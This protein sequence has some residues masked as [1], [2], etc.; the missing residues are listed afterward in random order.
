MMRKTRVILLI[1]LIASS[2][3]LV[4]K[5]LAYS[6]TKSQANSS[7]YK[8]SKTQSHLIVIYPRG[9]G[10]LDELLEGMMYVTKSP[11][12]T[13]LNDNLRELI[14][15]PRPRPIEVQDVN[16]VRQVSEELLRQA[17][18]RF[19]L[20]R[21]G[22]QN[23]DSLFS[24]LQ[25][26]SSAYKLFTQEKRN[27]RIWNKAELKVKDDELKKVVDA[28]FINDADCRGILS[29]LII[30]ERVQGINDGPFRKFGLEIQPILGRKQSLSD[31]DGTAAR[32]LLNDLQGALSGKWN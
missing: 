9:S 18:D 30:A 32:N 28:M 15:P 11:A 19:K 6:H 7:I 12:A 20:Q 8:S 24:N 17:I 16:Q 4:N 5:V 25:P 3:F 26:N 31:P 29:C 1:S 27:I 21:P 14:S 10:L 22:L 2:V 23:A 13:Q